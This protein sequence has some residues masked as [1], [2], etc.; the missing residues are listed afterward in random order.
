MSQLPQGCAEDVLNTLQ[1]SQT[2]LALELRRMLR[3][4]YEQDNNFNLAVAAEL[5]NAVQELHQDSD[6]NRA[7]GS[8][9]SG[10]STIHHRA[11]TIL[12]KASQV[13]LI[14][15]FFECETSACEEWGL[16]EDPHNE[17]T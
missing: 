8:F 3:A 17:L 9:S 16:F 4:N 15:S 14:L 10:Q 5:P 7:N 11:R 1:D 12:E 6:L 2:P 13:H